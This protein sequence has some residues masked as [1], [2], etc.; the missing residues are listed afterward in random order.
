MDMKKYFTI[1]KYQ[2]DNFQMHYS[3][4][5]SKVLILLITLK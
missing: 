2:L 1:N 3:I 4:L 5:S